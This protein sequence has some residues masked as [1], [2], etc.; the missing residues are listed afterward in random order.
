MPDYKK[1]QAK[2]KHASI[3]EPVEIFRRLPTPPGIADLY[4]SQAEVLEAWFKRRSD[5]DVVIKLHTGGGKTL[6]GLL[7]AQSTMNELGE[8]VIYLSPTTQLVDQTINK[9]SEYGISAVPY[10]KDGN[11]QDAFLT[12]QSIMVCTYQALFNGISRFGAPGSQRDPLHV[13]AVILDDAHAS[14]TALRN[15][16][17]L[18][19]SRESDEDLYLDLCNTFRA[20]FALIDRQGTFDDIVSGIDSGVL[21]VPY[22]A[23]KVRRDQLHSRLRSHA[24]KPEYKF[25]WPFLRDAFDYCHGFITKS[26]F[27]ITPIAPLVNLIP[28][29]SQCKRRVYMSATIADDSEIIR[30]FN[31]S[32]TSISKPISSKSLAGTSE[33]M[34]LAPELMK[35][36]VA[37]VPELVRKIVSW[38]ATKRSI[39]TVVLVPSMGAAA[40]WKAIADIPNSTEQVGEFVAQLQSGATH[41]PVVFANRYDGIDLPGRACQLLVVSGLPRGAHEYDQYRNT[42]LLGGGS[43][44]SAL[45]QRLEQGMGRAAR[46]A[47]DYCVVIVTGKDLVAWIGRTA[48]NRF[49][50]SSTRAQLEIGIEVSKDIGDKAAVLEAMESC[51]NRDKEWMRYHADALAESVGP[52]GIDDQALKQ[53]AAEQQAFRLWRDSHP[54]K[55]IAKIEEFCYGVTSLESQSKGWLLQL[56]ARIAH[57]WGNDKKSQDLQQHAFAENRNLFRPQTTPPYVAL[58]VPGR[59]AETIAESLCNFSPRRGFLSH[60]E[61]V[62]SH[63]VHESSSNQF[64]EALKD[65]GLL[66]GFAAERPE[67]TYGGVG[68]DVLWLLG[69]N[70]ALVIE[71][72]SRKRE[73]NALTKADLGQLLVAVEW[74]KKEYPNHPFTAVSVHPNVSATRNAQA[75]SVKALTYH[76]LQSLID[77][78]RN[79]FGKACEFIGEQPEL[80]VRCQ[81]LLNGSNLISGKIESK[82][83]VNFEIEET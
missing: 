20:D 61:D 47:G 62:V 37:D 64:E 49:L 26:T 67:K 1:L 32:Y 23:W 24:T 82:Y 14:F 13:G 77:D 60:F 40:Q 19:V 71:A 59:Q 31:A 28:T 69:S 45:A 35:F 48:N 79:L 78:A 9:A 34:I 57:Y 22:W 15:C 10:E 3:I 80:A 27:T 6:V 76:N 8:P 4:T 70:Q 72:K 36:K 38:A 7:I 75:D 18:R 5:Q 83:L 52:A 42:T 56:A 17:T 46:G 2:R 39:G 53:A 51:W 25:V 66:L 58:A 16:F 68:P 30:T 21:E 12:G 73:K 81:E 74:F 33:R 43:V 50:T 55:A 63:L 44:N 11:F 65:F 54:E 29:F 41:G